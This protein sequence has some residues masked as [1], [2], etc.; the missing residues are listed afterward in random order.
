MLKWL[1]K[2]MDK[3]KSP[4]WEVYFWIAVIA[5]AIAGTVVI[6]ID[7]MG[8]ASKFGNA[9]SF[10]GG[11]FTIAAVFIAVIAYK[12]S[13]IEHKENLLF[14]IKSEIEIQLFPEIEQ[15]I[16]INLKNLIPIINEV[17]REKIV[18]HENQKEL[19]DIKNNIEVPVQQ[20]I[21]KTAYLDKL[22]GLKQEYLQSYDDFL[23]LIGGIINIFQIIYY[24]KDEIDK[25]N[26]F[27]EQQ[28]ELVGSHSEFIK[29][30]ILSSIEQHK[31][32]IYD[33]LAMSTA[34][35]KIILK[36]KAYYGLEPN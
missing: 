9:G 32:H 30:H 18:S 7:P 4:Y 33:Y 10:L 29:K 26:Q 6:F 15:A 11:V 36:M 25:E 21:K 12:R 16:K 34:T 27:F 17:R 19:I 8:L 1:D 23:V 13:K 14:E 3:L 35:H 20:L 22:G 2:Y 24:H 28:L 31:L 5:I